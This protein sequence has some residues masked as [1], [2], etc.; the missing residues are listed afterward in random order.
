[1]DGAV[2]IKICMTYKVYW[3]RRNIDYQQCKFKNAECSRMQEL[4]LA[5]QIY[6]SPL[7]YEL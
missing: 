5:T 7:V 3:K 1:V 4:A 2:G 6:F